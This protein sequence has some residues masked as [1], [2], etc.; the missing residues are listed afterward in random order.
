MTYMCI[1]ETGLCSNEISMFKMLTVL[2]VSGSLVNK[3][4]TDYIPS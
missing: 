4:D 3:G 2:L 1:Y